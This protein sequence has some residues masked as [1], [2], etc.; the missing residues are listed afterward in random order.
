VVE[1]R[2]FAI[3]RG[4]S[5]SAIN[6]ASRITA[7][8]PLA[9]VALFVL[10]LGWSAASFARADDAPPTVSKLIEALHSE[11]KQTR[12]DAV[13]D[14]GRRG[15]SARESVP[16]LIKLIDDADQQISK[17]AISALGG[18]G[19]AASESIP[20][21]IDA[22]DSRKVRGGRASGRIQSSMRVALALASIGPAAIPPLQTALDSKDAA[23]RAGAWAPW[24]RPPPWRSLP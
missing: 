11:D 3:S 21:L 6:A 1:N 8:V 2:G 24:V 9:L 16:E 22:L 7:R 23:Q 12:R 20:A 13:V 4:K 19:P 18:I 17:N 15:E 14:L 5:D 10:S